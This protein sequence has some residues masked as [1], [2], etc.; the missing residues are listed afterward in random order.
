MNAS[1]MDGA[2]YCTNEQRNKEDMV[3]DLIHEFAHAIENQ[4]G[5]YIYTDG[6]IENE[7]LGKRNKLEL[8]LNFENYD[9]DQVDFL[10][11]KYDQNFDQFVYSELGPEKLNT[12]V[13]GLFLRGYSVVSLKEYFATGFEEFY[14]GDREYLKR[15]CPSLYARLTLINENEMEI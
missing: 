8:M 14:L 4:Y 3:D 13:S 15:L 7:F 11:S 5:Y 10:N 6:I 9:T 2:I 12:I 1:Y